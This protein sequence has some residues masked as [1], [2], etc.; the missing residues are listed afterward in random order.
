MTKVNDW[1]ISPSISLIVEEKRIC[2]FER[3]STIKIFIE[4]FHLQFH[5][6]VEG[7][8]VRYFKSD[9]MI[10]VNYWKISPSISLT[11]RRE[12]N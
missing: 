9:C 3:A 6:L 5:W 4:G 8:E 11:C 7:R 2:N 10:K 12:E 1:R